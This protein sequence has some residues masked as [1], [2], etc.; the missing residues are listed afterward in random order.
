MSL[1]TAW[2]MARKLHRAGYPYAEIATT[3]RGPDKWWVVANDRGDRYT[4]LTPADVRE[5]ISE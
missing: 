5:F 1:I 3:Y 2:L 4:L